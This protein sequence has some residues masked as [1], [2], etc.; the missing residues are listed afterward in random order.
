MCRSDVDA[1]AAEPLAVV[2]A[3]IAAAL[4]AQSTVYPS[5]VRIGPVDFGSRAGQDTTK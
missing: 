3:E 5:S 4:A 1:R 2:L